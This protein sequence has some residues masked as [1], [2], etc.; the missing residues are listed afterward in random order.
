M[1]INNT[2]I[3]LGETPLI[4]EACAIV[5]GRILFNFCL[6]SIEMDWILSEIEIIR[7]YHIF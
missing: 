3:S 7:N 1:Y 2:E 6:A 4:R 5:R